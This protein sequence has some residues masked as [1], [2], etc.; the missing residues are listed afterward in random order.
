MTMEEIVALRN[1]SLE[2]DK[3]RK[4]EAE[5]KKQEE[6][7]RLG[8]TPKPPKKPTYD[9]PNSLENDEATI[10]WIIAMIGGSIFVD[11]ILIWVGATVWW[12]LYITRHIRK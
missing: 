7:K 3:R 10:L 8:I 5:A 11:R 4:A 9:H 1:H 6:M 12:L 2:Q